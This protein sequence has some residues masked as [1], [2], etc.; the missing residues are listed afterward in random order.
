M[1]FKDIVGQE[2]LK[3]RLIKDIRAGRIP[4][5]QLFVG[6]MGHGGFPI[7]LAYAQ[8]LN[9]TNPSNLDS[10]GVCPSCVK[11]KKLVH[12][13][14][15]FVF[16]I[17]KSSKPKCE[18]CDDV[19]PLWREF[20]TANPYLSFDSWIRALNIGN[21]QPQIYSKESDELIRKLG[22]KASEGGYKVVLIWLP[23]KM[24][25][26]CANKLLKL[27]EEPPVKTVFLL[28]AEETEHMLPTVLSRTQQ[29]FI[30]P[31]LEADLLQNLIE[32]HKVDAEQ[33]SKIVQQAG[34]NLSFAL[35]MLKIE[36]ESEEFFKLF[37]KLMRLAYLR[38]VKEIEKWSEEVASWG[39]EKQKSF[40]QFSQRMVRE[41][42]IFNFNQPELNYLTQMEQGF[43]SNFSPFINER[44]VTSISRELSE[45]ERHIEQNVNAKMV[46]F[47]FSLKM[48]V[49]LR[50]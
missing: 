50:Q 40:L 34:G 3:N 36:H 15:H 45:A 2:E 41:S 42:F 21:G 43:A 48:I 4:H 22:L 28:I 8:Y 47:D 11:Y 12:P 6:P 20:V 44:N 1:F 49:L 30:P 29:L 38:S 14:L 46:F 17:L 13:D 26:A 25:I 7:A 10:C 37:V 23:E 19:L 32:V 31:I 16:P 5:A 9:C 18:L 24:N 35:E 39:R 33:S 27:F